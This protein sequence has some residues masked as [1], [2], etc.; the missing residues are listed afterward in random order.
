[1]IIVLKYIKCSCKE[2][3]Q[4][5]FSVHGGQLKKEVRP[6]LEMRMGFP[7]VRAAKHG[8]N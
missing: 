3:G 2:T 7:A 8:E 1:M 4:C 6:R 5:V